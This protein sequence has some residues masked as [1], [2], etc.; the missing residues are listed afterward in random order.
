MKR[1]WTLSLC[2]AA[3]LT[4]GLAAFAEVSGMQQKTKPKDDYT[5]QQPS[6]DEMQQMMERWQATMVTGKYHRWL[7]RFVGQWET[8][9]KM[10]WAP[11]K[12]PEETKG[13]AEIAWQVKDRWLAWKSTWNMMGQ[14]ITTFGL[15]GYDN[16]KQK[17]VSVGYDDRTTALYRFEGNLDQTGKVLSL[18]GTVDEPMTGEH[19]K[20][21]MYVLRVLDK[22]HFVQEIHDLTIG[23][24]QTKVVEM[25]Y[26]RKQ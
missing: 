10:M 19:D 2:L 9:N 21:S 18:W 1:K 12:D 22:D 20:M 3:S 17:F 14:P 8:T 23:G 6:A 5:V 11:G 25:L 4:V 26:T 13:H 16:F 24:D 7:G 15:H